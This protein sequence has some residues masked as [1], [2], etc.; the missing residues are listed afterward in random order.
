MDKRKKQR[1]FDRAVNGLA[2]QKFEQSA[3]SHG[4]CVYRASNGMRCAVGHLIRDCDYDSSYEGCHIYS[5]LERGLLILGHAPTKS[6]EA[7]FLSDLQ[8]CH[9]EAKNPAEMKEALKR[10]AKKHELK[11]PRKLYGA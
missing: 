5:A 2:G 8:D 9:D 7:H 4:E 11:I 10:F 6:E 1:W 3:A